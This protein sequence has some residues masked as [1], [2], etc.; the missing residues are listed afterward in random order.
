MRA[1]G[2]FPA[3]TTGS[4]AVELRARKAISAGASRVRE[5]GNDEI[6]TRERTRPSLLTPLF[7]ARTAVQRERL[8]WRER[9]WWPPERAADGRVG[10]YR[11]P[12]HRERKSPV[13]NAGLSRMPMR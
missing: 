2:G 11:T 5:C 13:A 4:P 8:A 1:I 3:M 7:W 6:P 9:A 12:L 10:I